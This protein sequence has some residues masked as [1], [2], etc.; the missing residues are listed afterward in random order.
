MKVRDERRTGRQF[1][2]VLPKAEAEALRRMARE[3]NK[4]ITQVIR[5]LVRNAERTNAEVRHVAA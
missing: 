1:A 3:Q 5:T 4:S 2:I